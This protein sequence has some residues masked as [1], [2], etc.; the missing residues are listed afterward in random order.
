MNADDYNDRDQKYSQ[1]GEY[2]LAIAD[3]NFGTALVIRED[4]D[5]NIHR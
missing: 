5:D 3:F 4:Y 1:S 2:D